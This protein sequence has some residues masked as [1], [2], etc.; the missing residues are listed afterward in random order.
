MGMPQPVTGHHQGTRPAVYSF[1]DR[2]EM[3][4]GAVS[5]NAAVPSRAVMWVGTAGERFVAER[6]EHRAPAAEQETNCPPAQKST[7]Q[8]ILYVKQDIAR[9]NA[10]E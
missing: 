5:G 6:S 4:F 1:S 3:R 8:R 7:N 10:Q 2:R 9:G